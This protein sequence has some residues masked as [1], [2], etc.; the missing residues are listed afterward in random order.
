M[1]HAGKVNRAG[2]VP[3]NAREHGPTL[4]LGEQEQIVEFG[5]DEEEFDFGSHM[6]KHHL[7]A[8][9]GGVPMHHHQG[10]Q[11]GR[12]DFSGCAEINDKLPASLTHV[13]KQGVRLLTKWFA[14]LK[15]EILG[16][17]QHP[18][19]GLHGGNSQE[20]SGPGSPA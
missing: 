16:R 1:T 4:I 12:I 6:R 10:A 7:L 15:S 14:G 19:M 9:L 5:Q 8:T 17:L 18:A 11:P 20:A 13:V 3:G 2:L